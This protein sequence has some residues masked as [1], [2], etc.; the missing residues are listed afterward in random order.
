MVAAASKARLARWCDL[1]GLASRQTSPNGQAARVGALHSTPHSNSLPRASDSGSRNESSSRDQQASCC[2]HAFPV[3]SCTS[4][5]EGLQR[6]RQAC[7]QRK[8]AEAAGGWWQ[9]Q[10]SAGQPGRAHDLTHAVAA[11]DCAPGDCLGDFWRP[12]PGSPWRQ[13]AYM[14]AGCTCVGLSAGSK[15]GCLSCLRRREQVGPWASS[16]RRH[17][18]AGA[19]CGPPTSQQRTPAS[20]QSP[21]AARVPAASGGTARAGSTAAAFALGSRTAG[22]RIGR[23]WQTSLARAIGPPGAGSTHG[24]PSCRS[25]TANCCSPLLQATW[26]A[27][28]RSISSAW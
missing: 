23:W 8:A 3:L 28:L 26:R 13:G 7:R 15:D 20:Q 11:E 9:P 14:G 12:E 27:V 16:M 17:A 18:P 1:Q 19:W 24:R 4:T 22:W 5:S 2:A 21:A 6:Q 10:A 25:P